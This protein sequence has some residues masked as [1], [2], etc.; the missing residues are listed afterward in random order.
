MKKLAAT[1]LIGS[2]AST[3]LANLHL[4]PEAELMESLKRGAITIDTKDKIVLSA[5]LV[6][7]LKKINYATVNFS[8]PVLI[9]KDNKIFINDPD[10]LQDLITPLGQTVTSM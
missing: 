3:S 1:L 7:I 10:L 8:R 4:N 6:E 9:F 2:M 5:E